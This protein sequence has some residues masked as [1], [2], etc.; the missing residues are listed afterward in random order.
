MKF[1]VTEFLSLLAALDNVDYTQYKS[2][3]LYE[4]TASD[5][6]GTNTAPMTINVKR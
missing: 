3:N 2:T 4:L 1:S 6:S 5:E